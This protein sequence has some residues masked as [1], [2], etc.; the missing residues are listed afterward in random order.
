MANKNNKVKNRFNL[1]VKEWKDYD[2]TK[3]IISWERF[4]RYDI[5]KNI[6]L[7]NFSD[8]KISILEIGCGAGKNISQIAKLNKNWDCTGVDISD[9]M[10]KFCDN[11]Y[12]KI[13]NV[14]FDV[15]NVEK[16]KLNKKYDFVILLGVVGYFSNNKKAFKNINSMVK[17]GGNLYFTYGNKFSL[18]RHLRYFLV[19]LLNN[20]KIKSIYDKAN[21]REFNVKKIHFNAYGRKAILNNL[22]DYKLLK[23]FNLCFASGALGQYSVKSS[24]QIEKYFKELNLFGLA[25]T[26]I[27]YLKK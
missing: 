14:K 13:K 23:E 21:N 22:K 26:K 3:D 19:G 12:K 7:K 8:K 9:E 4:K 1:E 18:F 24:K 25:M 11:E 6:L 10:I 20:K 5:L 15:L 2:S 16:S 27:L 17:E